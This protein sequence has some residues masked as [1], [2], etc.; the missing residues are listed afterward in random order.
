MTAP[1]IPYFQAPRSFARNEK[2]PVKANEGW[3]LEISP[4]SPQ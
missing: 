3:L 2:I 1:R 4:K